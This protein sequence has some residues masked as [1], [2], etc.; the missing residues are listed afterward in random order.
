MV[1]EEEGISPCTS[2]ISTSLQVS[3]EK[4]I[5]EEEHS[6]SISSISTGPQVQVLVCEAEKCLTDGEEEE[7]GISFTKLAFKL[8][9]FLVCLVSSVYCICFMT[10]NA[11]VKLHARESEVN[12]EVIGLSKMCSSRRNPEL[13]CGIEEWVVEM[14]EAKPKE[15]DVTGLTSEGDGMFTGGELEVDVAGFTPEVEE[16]LS[17]GIMDVRKETDGIET[18]IGLLA[19]GNIVE[20]PEVELPAAG[21]EEILERSVALKMQV[22]L[23]YSM[24]ALACLSIL[25]AS[26]AY[27]H[28]HTSK[29][30]YRKKKQNRASE[31]DVQRVSGAVKKSTDKM[32]ANIVGNSKMYA[33][34]TSEVEF[35]CES[36]L[37]NSIMVN[38]SSVELQA[39]NVVDASVVKGSLK[40]VELQATP[41]APTTPVASLEKI[42]KVCTVLH[43]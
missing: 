35:L 17:G 18:D 27:L 13:T 32:S 28:K 8:V 23:L 43:F 19:Q 41:T 10:S 14:E 11:E 1:D 9:F 7:G 15:F 40:E 42:E 20:S 33:I 16:M 34:Q 5:Q 37:T 22:Y 30:F 6:P 24:Q 21:D 38:G 3:A 4:G 25:I 36:S 39:M 31:T 2:S 29:Q 12:A 26:I